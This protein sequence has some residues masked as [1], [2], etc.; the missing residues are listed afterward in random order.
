MGL[1]SNWWKRGK[2]RI[3]NR[4]HPFRPN[5]ALLLGHKE[6]GISGA[7]HGNGRTGPQAEEDPTANDD[8]PLKVILPILLKPDDVSEA[9]VLHPAIVRRSGE[10]SR[11]PRCRRIH[12]PRHR[13]G[14]HVSTGLALIF[15]SRA[16]A[17]SGCRKGRTGFITGVTHE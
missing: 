5:R 16:K 6:Q 9:Y 3:K 13:R 10:D 11:F 12:P 14:L 7:G 2:P 17:C 4:G 15:L 8:V 1:F